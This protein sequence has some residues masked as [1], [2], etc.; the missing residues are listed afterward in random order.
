MSVSAL[1]VV[2]AEAMDVRKPACAQSVHVIKQ[3]RE[4]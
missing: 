1:D 3:A 4:R 2:T